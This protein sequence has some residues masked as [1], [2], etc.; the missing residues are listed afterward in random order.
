MTCGANLMYL[1]LR[2]GVL[3]PFLPANVKLPCKLRWKTP[4][5]SAHL[6]RK[7][8]ISIGLSFKNIFLLQIEWKKIT[9]LPISPSN[10]VC[11]RSAL[12]SLGKEWNHNGRYRWIKP[13]PSCQAATAVHICAAGNSSTRAHLAPGY[14]ALP[15]IHPGVS[16]VTLDLQSCNGALI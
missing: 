9:Y 12:G 5:V 4:P 14:S 3:L 11:I 8:P 2:R 7:H 16:T 13:I 10:H 6:Q 15:G 1:P